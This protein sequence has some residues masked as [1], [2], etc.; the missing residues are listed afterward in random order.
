MTDIDNIKFTYDNDD[1]SDEW[2][3]ECRVCEKKR[4][5]VRTIN[6]L[7]CSDFIC[8]KCS[9][10]K[11]NRSSCQEC[12]IIPC[13]I[14]AHLHVRFVVNILIVPNV[15]KILMNVLEDIK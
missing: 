1:D 12:N 2:I 10:E 6:C 13:V 7:F 15:T 3:V 5:L 9:E 8:I 14:I 11:P 4:D